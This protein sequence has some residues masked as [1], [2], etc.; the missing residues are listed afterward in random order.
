L[1]GRQASARTSSSSAGPARWASTSW[2]SRRRT[3]LK[4]SIW[5]R[6]DDD[7]S[8]EEFYRRL[9]ENAVEGP[10]PEIG[11]LSAAAREAN[12]ALVVGVNERKPDTA[13]TM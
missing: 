2:C 10:D 1:T 4:N 9:S 5:S 7:R 6:F 11:R 3:S 8:V 12:V 13:G